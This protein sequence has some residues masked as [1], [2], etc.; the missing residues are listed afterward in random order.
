M[1]RPKNIESFGKESFFITV[2]VTFLLILL[3]VLYRNLEFSKVWAFGDLFAFPT[4]IDVIESW[5]FHLWNQEGL[6]SLSFKP[7]N[8]HLTVLATSYV[9]GSFL[10]QKV[11]FLSSLGVSFLAFYFL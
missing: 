6:G 8:F 9:L 4:K 7:F 3:L 11:V 5:A 10:A 2:L 1:A